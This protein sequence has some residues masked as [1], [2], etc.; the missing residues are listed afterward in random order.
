MRLLQVDLAI[1]AREVAVRAAV[2]RREMFTGGIERD[3][4]GASDVGGALRRDDLL[5]SPIPSNLAR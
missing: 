3:H 4:W 2:Q 1:E 5:A